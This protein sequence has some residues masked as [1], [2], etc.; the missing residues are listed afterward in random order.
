V[1]AVHGPARADV[2]LLHLANGI[3]HTLRI[4][5]PTLVESAFGTLTEATC[6]ARLASWSDALLAYAE[7][8]LEV[9]GRE[10]VPLDEALVVMSNHQSHYDIPVLFQ[11]LRPMRLRMVAKKE[12]FRIPIWAAAMRVA[13]FV[14][15]SRGDRSAAIESLSGARASIQRGTS[16]WLAPE[17]TRSPTGKLGSF[18][19][20]GFH[21]ASEAGARVLPVTVDG[22]RHVLPAKGARVA[23]G[24]RVRVVV[25]APVTIGAFEEHQRDALMAR[26][27][28]AIASGLPAD[29]R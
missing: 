7:V 16:I 14:E 17:G 19:K 20:G 21:L 24:Q 18:K 6:D 25:H 5:V 27:R 29:A 23:N 2:T 4:C 15:L 13:G 11:A 12:L 9:E 3:F 22:T 28:D 8:K 26:V 10:H 1:S